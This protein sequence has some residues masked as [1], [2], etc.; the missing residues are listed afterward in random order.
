MDTACTSCKKSPPEVSLK[1]CAKCS[2]T[3]YCSKDCQKADWKSHKKTC[4]RRANLSPP[5]GLERGV[6]CPFTRLDNG[7]WLHDRP[8]KD[9][10]RLLI[11]A[12][13]L[14]VADMYNLEGEVDDDSLYS[15]ASDGLRGFQR[16]LGRVASRPGLLPPWWDASKK[17]DCEAFGMTPEQGNARAYLACAVEKSDITEKYGDPQF[18]MQLRMLAEAVYGRAPGGSDGTAMRK[19]MVAMEQGQSGD[20]HTTHMDVS[21]MS[22]R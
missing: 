3:P 17:R 5:K 22:G 16:F 4:G 11:D 6:A 13:R 19:L 2:T 9:V 8:E 14:H 21:G 20:V 10:Y 1:R 7:T 18:P 15:G 12:Y